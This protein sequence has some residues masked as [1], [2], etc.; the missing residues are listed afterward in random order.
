MTTSPAPPTISKI[1]TIDYYNNYYGHTIEHLEML[2][3]QFRN[4]NK[5]ILFLVGDST[6][7]NKH[8]ILNT[9]YKKYQ[10]IN[11]YEKILYPPY[12]IGDI[13]FNINVYL[14]NTNFV[15]INCA[16]E[17]S[18]LLEK[19]SSLNLQD[20]F[21]RDHIRE[22]DIL[23]VS[24]GGNDIAL[25]PDTKIMINFGLLY[26]TNNIE[27]IKNN[28]LTANGITYFKT[29]FKNNMKKYL[30]GLTSIERPKNI[31][32]SGLYFPDENTQSISWAD[33]SLN[34]LNYNNNPDK[35][36][37]IIKSLYEYI[38]FK[39][40]IPINITDT[41]IQNEINIIPFPIYNVLN[42]KIT[43]DYIKRVEPSHFGGKKMAQ[44]LY[45]ILLNNKLM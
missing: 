28:P 4:D 34:L 19:T 16:V 13:C 1:S 3:N 33:N 39:I 25:K 14:K 5:N 23:L 35:L 43:E 37:S 38:L 30:L 9:K 31:I 36:Q 6:F 32:L 24:L 12:M 20:K 18:S 27:T 10:A 29:V 22:N 45:N 41:K 2:I 15:C 44:Y 42:G 17:E 8:W 11:C 7:D 40:R 21:V 26:Y